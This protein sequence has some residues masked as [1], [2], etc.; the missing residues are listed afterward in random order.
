LLQANANHYH[1]N[2][3]AIPSSSGASSILHAEGAGLNINTL[4]N[5]VANKENNRNNTQTKTKQHMQPSVEQNEP[6]KH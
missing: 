1:I 3:P 2:R 4:F 5:L 6:P